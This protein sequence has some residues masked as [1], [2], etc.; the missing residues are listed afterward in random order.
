MAV[1]DGGMAAWEAA[2]LPLEAGLER[3]ASRPDDEYL[4]PYDRAGGV[5]QAMRDYIT[6]EIG[7]VPEV[8]A[9]GDAAFEVFVG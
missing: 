6:W 8:E 7:L 9:D 5:E 1:L 3:L 2:G 4:R